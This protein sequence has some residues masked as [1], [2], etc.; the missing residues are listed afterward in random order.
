MLEH[1]GVFG[2]VIQN[3]NSHKEFGLSVINNFFCYIFRS[4]HVMFET[5]RGKKPKRYKGNILGG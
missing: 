3:Q 1:F 2:I 5:V 4:L